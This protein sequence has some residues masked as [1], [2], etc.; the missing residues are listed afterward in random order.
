MKYFWW[1][2]L[3]YAAGV[4]VGGLIIFLISIYLCHKCLG[5]YTTVLFLAIWVAFMLLVN[6][7]FQKIIPQSAKR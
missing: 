4:F 2:L 6:F 1:R 7:V 5:S 3:D